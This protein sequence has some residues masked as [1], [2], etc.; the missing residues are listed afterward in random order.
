MKKFYVL[1]LIFLFASKAAGQ[2]DTEHWFA[3]MSQK[4]MTGND[5]TFLYLSTNETVPFL[6]KVESDNQVIDSVQLSKGKPAKIRLGETVL[7]ATGGNSVRTVTTKGLHVYG[8]K[9]FFAN[10]RFSESNHAEIIT[11]KGRAG[12]GNKFLAAYAPF[13]QDASPLNYTIAVIAT[14]DNTAVDMMGEKIFLNKAQSYIVNGLPT[15]NSKIGAL[16][17][18]DKPISVTNGNYNGQYASANSDAGSDILM[19]QAVPVE[20]LGRE[21]ILMKGNGSIGEG[22]ESALI[23]AAEDN[24]SIFFNNETTPA[25]HLNKGEYFLMPSQKYNQQNGSGVFNAYIHSTANVYV[26]QLLSG[27]GTLASG[28]FNYIPPLNCYL[29][30]QIDELG[31]IDENIGYVRSLQSNT[32]YETHPTKF[33]IITQN[34]ATVKLN[35]TLLNG[36]F[37]PYPVIGTSEW[38]TFMVPDVK[39]NLTLESTKAVT[40]GIAAGDAAVGY[41]GYFAGASSLPLITKAGTCVPGAYL[42]VD[43]NFENFRWQ[44]KNLQTGIFEDIPGATQSKYTPYQ[45]GEYKVIVGTAGCGTIESPSYTLLSCPDTSS[46]GFTA[47]SKIVIKPTFSKSKQSI[48]FSKLRMLKNPAY[49]TVSVSGEFITYT[50]NPN[51]TNNTTDSFVYIIEGDSPLPD[52]EIVTVDIVLKTFSVPDTELS[53]CTKDGQGIFDLTALLTPDI[54]A[55]SFYEDQNLKVPVSVP[56][57]SKFRTSL[58]S[59]FAKMDSKTGCSTVAEVALK[60]L[61]QPSITL[62]KFNSIFCDGDLDG[63]VTVKFSDIT[64]Q[65]VPNAEVFNVSYALKS[66]PDIPL[67]DSYTFF[68]DT[69]IV[70]T[71]KSKDN[72]P[73][74]TAGFILKIK[75]KIALN[76]VPEIEICDNDLNNQEAVNL[77][78]YAAQF[79]QQAEASYY[80]T[81]TDAR[82]NINAISPQQS[83]NGNPTFYLRFENST[84]CAAVG[85]LNFKLKKPKTSELLISQTICRD[86]VALLDAGSGFDSYLWSTGETTS[87]INV[88]PGNYYVDLGFNGCVYRQAVTVSIA[89]VPQI[90]EIKTEGTAAIVSATG[91]TAP[92][93]YSLD[94][95]AWQNSNRFENL[96]YGLWKVYV[97]DANGCVIAEKEFLILRL[98]N[99]ITPNGDGYNDVLDYSDLRIKKDVSIQIFDRYGRAVFQSSG[100]GFIWNGTSGGR[101][102]PTDTYWYLLRWNEPDTGENKAYKGWI[103]V[104]NR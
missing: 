53:S 44:I 101:V 85:T 76:A 54:Q 70:I 52:S 34:G 66:H 3:P 92:Y 31:F 37:G 60:Y 95:I 77:K 72:C 39:G 58:P 30:K 91:G 94:G 73:A 15:D 29:P 74:A 11:S 75:E 1:L 64:P 55:M 96:P 47:C 88:K 20:R 10:L 93:S 16:I 83:I 78:D 33:N 102:V 71:V 40:A 69:P 22:M 61:Q 9:K 2:M 103:L 46:L 51:F 43:E 5:F 49:G 26:Y 99:T 28:G 36:L 79:T 32:Y 41:G 6:V 62:E 67:P 63:S 48:T 89:T 42:E 38:V 87:S 81:L 18:A 90:S 8:N 86:A 80:R 50:P 56:D 17:T 98:V 19:D 13:S 24:T 12:L 14:E 23:I 57:L 84:E 104:K 4:A 25:K 59:I 68:G 7:K 21:Y 35:G 45:P 27:S 65:I 100:Q 97:K 82:Q